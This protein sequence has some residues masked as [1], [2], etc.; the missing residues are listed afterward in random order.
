MSG[1]PIKNIIRILYDDLTSAVFSVIKTYQK[2]LRNELEAK[3]KEQGYEISN[4]DNCIGQLKNLGIIKIED[5]PQQSQNRNERKMSRKSMIKLYIYNGIDI[6]SLKNKYE[7]MKKNMR[8][9][10]DERV[11]NKYICKKCL[12]QRD[13]NKASRTN[14]QCE[15][16]KIPYC[17]KEEDISDLNKKCNIIFEVLDELFAEEENNSNYGSNSNINNYLS[18]K[19]GKN[20]IGENKDTFEEDHES[21]IYQTIEN[22]PE[23]SKSNFYEL[24]E[25][26]LRSKK[27]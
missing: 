26:F 27:K 25:G 24:V 1:E 14:F 4:L 20:F 10:L 8:N 12:I 17:K 2:R 6:N 15:F 9:D 7:Q 18:S 11:K 13:D 21:Y 22:L 19:Y 16:C 5:K 23:K 3:L